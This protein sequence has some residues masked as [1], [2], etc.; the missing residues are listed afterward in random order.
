[1]KRFIALLLAAFLLGGL[2]GCNADPDAYVPTGDGLTWEEDYT[3]PVYTHPQAQ[4]DQTLTLIYY[5]NKPLNPLECTDYTNRVLFSLIYQPLFAVSGSYEPVPI[6]CREYAISEDMKTYYIYLEK[7]T[8]SDGTAL[9]AADVLATYKAAMESPYY[10]GRFTHI[11]EVSL[12]GSDCVVFTLD[13]PMADL[14]LLLD[15]PR[16]C[17]IS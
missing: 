9:T 5:P 1:M 3:G 13:T 8:F 2:V 16:C 11:E 17:R 4:E 10:G 15:V 12:L 6:L 14:P 7:A